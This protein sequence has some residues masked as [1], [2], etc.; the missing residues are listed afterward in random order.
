MVCLIF[1]DS[2][3]SLLNMRRAIRQNKDA[4]VV[5]FLGDGLADAEILAGEFPALAWIAVRGN[6]D[7]S[8][9]F[10]NSTAEKVERITLEGK[11]IVLTHGDLYG[12]KFSDTRL[13]YLAMEEGADILLFGHTHEPYECFVSDAEKPFWIFN[14]GSVSLARGSFGVLTIRDGVPL[15]SHGSFL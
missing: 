14:P 15:F 3:G 11:K 1:S 7:M 5:F 10:L 13:R 4:E 8:S 6:C 9:V 2:H 12:A